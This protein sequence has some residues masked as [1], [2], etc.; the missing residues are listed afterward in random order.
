MARGKEKPGRELLRM[1]YEVHREFDPIWQNEI[2]GREETY[3]WLASQ[4]NL[5]REDT[6]I[7]KF[8]RKMCQQA[9]EVIKAFRLENNF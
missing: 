3:Y 1:R 6:H 5:P 7:S 9:L 2:M 8:N 4:M